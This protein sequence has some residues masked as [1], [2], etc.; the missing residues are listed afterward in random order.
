MPL[1]DCREGFDRLIRVQDRK[2][3]EDDVEMD[4]VASCEN[5]GECR[6]DTPSAVGQVSKV[7]LNTS[8][9]EREKGNVTA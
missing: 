5:R 4:R 7:S 8:L 2:L 6:N 3:V 9:V 1:S